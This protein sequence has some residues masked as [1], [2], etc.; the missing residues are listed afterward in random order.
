MSKDSWRCLII[1][2]M[3]SRMSES[4][5]FTRSAPL[6]SRFKISALTRRSVE[7]RRAWP[8][9]IASLMALLIS[10][11]STST[12]LLHGL[13]SAQPPPPC[14]DH[15]PYRLDYAERPGTLHKSIDRSQRTSACERQDECRAAILKGI[16]DQHGGDGKQ[17][18]YG[19]PVHVAQNSLTRQ[20]A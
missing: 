8:D 14:G 17:A 12:S 1:L 11:R 20:V 13:V 7:T 5:S 18:E 15:G 10:S 9:F 6:V 19:K 2:P 4:E 16:A 3:T